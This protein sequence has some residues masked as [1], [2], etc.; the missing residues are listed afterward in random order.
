MSPQGRKRRSETLPQ[1]GDLIRL[2]ILGPNPF[3]LVRI[4]AITASAD[5]TSLR[6]RP[7]ADPTGPQ[8]RIAH[9]YKAEATNTFSLRVALSEK[10]QWVVEAHIN[11]RNELPNG[12]RGFAA[13]LLSRLGLQALQW[14]PLLRDL[15]AED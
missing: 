9:L 6:V 2:K 14:N 1:E 12:I 5:M 4:D 3:D 13:L 7:C 8:H 10:G 11:G 15:I